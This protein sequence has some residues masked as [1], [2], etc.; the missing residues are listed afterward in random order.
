MLGVALFEKPYGLISKFRSF[1]TQKKQ[2]K[3][4]M[5]YSDVAPF[6]HKPY[7]KLLKKCMCEALLD[8]KEADFLSHMVDK[9]SINYLDWSYRSPWLKDHMKDVAKRYNMEKQEQLLMFEDKSA[10]MGVLLGDLSEKKRGTEVHVPV[11]LVARQKG[12]GPW[13]T[14]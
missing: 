12:N 14:R 13:K 5:N 6:G 9:Y 11:E 10:K 2:L 1:L 7:L 8:D 3:A 4:L